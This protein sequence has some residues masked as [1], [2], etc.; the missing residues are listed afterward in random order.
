[1]V[2]VPVPSDASFASIRIAVVVTSQCDPCPSVDLF[3]V[4]LKN[5]DDTDSAPKQ[6]SWLH[7]PQLGAMVGPHGL[8]SSPFFFGNKLG[9]RQGN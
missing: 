7:C 1:M 3:A 8:E 6:P 5:D 4:A 9:D 2:H